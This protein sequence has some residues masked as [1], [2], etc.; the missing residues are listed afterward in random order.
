MASP[1]LLDAI[2]INFIIIIIIQQG[3][4]AF[5]IDLKDTYLHSPIVKHHC[6]LLQF[7]W[8]N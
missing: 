4:Y 8:G 1:V 3:N 5:F 2:E 7:V 6:W